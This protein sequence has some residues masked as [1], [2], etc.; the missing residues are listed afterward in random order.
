MNVKELSGN[1]MAQELRFGLVV[2]RFNDFLTR[3]LLAGAVD[4]PLVAVMAGTPEN[5]RPPGRNIEVFRA[6]PRFKTAVESNKRNAPIVSDWDSEVDH[7]V[8][9]GLRLLK[10]QLSGFMLP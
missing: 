5:Y 1:L 4:C 3:E 2:S 8:S 9:A 6:Q 10:A 7:V